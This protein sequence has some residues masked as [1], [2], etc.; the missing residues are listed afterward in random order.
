VCAFRHEG[1]GVRFMIGLPES[2]AKLLSGF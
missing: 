2:D 1:A